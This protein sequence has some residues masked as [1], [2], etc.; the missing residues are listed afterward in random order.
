M[1]TGL[2]RSVDRLART[3]STPSN[4]EAIELSI[5]C[6]LSLTCHS[7][8]AEY[9]Y[10]YSFMVPG[11]SIG[12]YSCDSTFFSEFVEFDTTYIGENDGRSWTKVYNTLTSSD[13]LDLT[14][15][16]TSNAFHT[17]DIATTAGG[18]ASTVTVT[19][20]KSTPVAAIAGG[21]VGGVLAIS[22]VVAGSLWFCLRRRKQNN[23]T[24]TNEGSAAAATIPGQ[25]P[26]P[27]MAQQKPQIESVY[28]AP[29]G[30]QPPPQSP[31]QGY[32]PP[33]QNPPQ[34]LAS[35]YYG[36][37]KQDYMQNQQNPYD[38][39][40]AAKIHG[41][42]QVTQQEIHAPV[43][44]AP[45]YS[46]VIPPVGGIS[47]AGS[48]PPNVQEMNAQMPTYGQ[49]QNMQQNVGGAPP[50]QQP[51]Q[52]LPTQFATTLHTAEGQPIYEAPDQIYRSIQ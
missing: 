2:H 14:V 36:Q 22:A 34:G 8:D 4:G 11:V 5:N 7:T 3:I 18:S 26:A 35:D 41:S 25:G 45:P 16:E 28:G 32:Q 21:V 52:E 47:P 51:V 13:G 38:P 1:V 39:T 17:G 27:D 9:P 12:W 6:L 44:P 15:T 49:F 50:H 48:P 19:A 20:S 42:P 46:Q 31:P 10:C 23:Q 33:P 24:A 29:G 37:G 40:M 43:S 30:Y